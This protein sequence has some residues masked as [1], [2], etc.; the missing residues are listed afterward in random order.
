MAKLSSGA[1]LNEAM[2]L[3]RAKRWLEK[4]M[5]KVNLGMNSSNAPMFVHLSTYD[6]TEKILEAVDFHKS[7]ASM[8]ENLVCFPDRTRALVELF[9][10]V[11]EYETAVDD[12]LEERGLTPENLAI[13]RQEAPCVI[14]ETE[15]N[16]S[17]TIPEP[18]HG[19]NQAQVATK[20][21]TKTIQTATTGPNPGTVSTPKTGKKTSCE[22]RQLQDDQEQPRAPLTPAHDKWRIVRNFDKDTRAKVAC[23]FV[24]ELDGDQQLESISFPSTNILSLLVQQFVLMMSLNDPKTPL[25]PK[26]NYVDLTSKNWEI[27]T[28][29]DDKAE[30]LYRAKYKNRALPT[31]AL[32]GRGKN[33]LPKWMRTNDQRPRSIEEAM[34]CIPPSV[35]I[36][37]PKLV[38]L[39]KDRQGLAYESIEAALQMEAAFFLE[40]QFAVATKSS[41]RHWYHQTLD[42]M[43]NILS[44][45]PSIVKSSP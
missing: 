28:Y 44:Q 6:Q 36:P 33:K 23:L 20:K 29:E 9:H 16:T 21:S 24:T 30:I 19:P 37:E 12:S 41:M 15:K 38:N 13:W 3:A 40:L 27:L 4:R 45:G 25:S 35:T 31:M 39:S 32:F 26:K 14:E 10:G 22:E 42:A 18:T 34:A 43:I 17:R 8:G 7:C 5:E 11:E 2:L 1:D